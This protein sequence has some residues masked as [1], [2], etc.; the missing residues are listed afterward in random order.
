MAQEYTPK[1][2][3]EWKAAQDI[4]LTANID[5]PV[6]QTDED[7][8]FLDDL[9]Q[10]ALTYQAAKE[11]TVA[12]RKDKTNLIAIADQCRDLADA[13]AK[14][15]P[16]PTSRLSG[17]ASQPLNNLFTDTFENLGEVES[18]LRRSRPPIIRGKKPN[19]HLNVL[20]ELLANVYER[21]TRK[22]ATVYTERVDNQR[23]GQIVGF[24][25][26][27]NKHFLFGEIENINAR[28]IQRVLQTRPD[29]ATPPSL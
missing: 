27:F 23:V 20:I 28:A 3:K 21:H 15:D 2:L 19:E 5:L 25:E 26:A 1:E 11:A 13:L 8:P 9:R 22:Q 12:D 17:A 16:A 18:A 29:N 10:V 4:W 7:T 24:V 14:L 6:K